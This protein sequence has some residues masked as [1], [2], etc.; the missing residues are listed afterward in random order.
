M[1]PIYLDH[2]ASTPVLPEVI[3]RIT[4]VLRNTWGNPSSHHRHG[5]EAA[6]I[7]S[8]SRAQVAKCVK[9]NSKGIY[10]TS[11]A[12]EAINLG[13]RTF[14]KDRRGHVVASKVEHKAVLETLRDLE[15][16]GQIEITWIQ[17]TLNGTLEPEDFSTVLRH[18]T[19]LAVCIWVNNETGAINRIPEIHKILSERGVPVFCDATQAIGKVPVD[20]EAHTDIATFSGHKIGGPKGVGALWVNPTLKNKMRPIV[21]G[22]GQESGIRPGTENLPGIAGFAL[23]CEIATQRQPEVAEHCANLKILLLEL[24]QPLDARVS[25]HGECVPHIISLLIPG[26]D[27]QI[28]LAQMREEASFSLG[29]ACNSLRHE[30]SPV[31]LSSGLSEEAANSTVRI[32]LAGETE[33]CEITSFALR[34]SNHLKGELTI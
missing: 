15:S 30:P 31:L 2:A 22:G 17:P 19:C 27:N 32:S 26:A 23:A 28:L 11:G 21:T 6:R 4:D 18:D 5:F 13:L 1:T 12:T 24:L 16:S 29:S 10:F 9:A 34:L 3:D 25:I 7:L 14:F 8:E 33:E 20:L